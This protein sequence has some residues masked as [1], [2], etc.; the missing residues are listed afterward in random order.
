[1]Q[2][3]VQSFM[4]SEVVEKEDQIKEK[5]LEAFRNPKVLTRIF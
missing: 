1:M 2:G 5:L 3:D 4:K